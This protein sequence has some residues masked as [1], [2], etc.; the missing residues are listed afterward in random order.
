V[1]CASA[2]SFPSHTPSPFVNTATRHLHRLLSLVQPRPLLLNSK[3]PLRFCIDA[4]PAIREALGRFNYLNLHYT[5][6]KQHPNVLRFD[7]VVT[8]TTVGEEKKKSAMIVPLLFVFY[9]GRKYGLMLYLYLRGRVYFVFVL[10]ILL[11]FLQD[12]G[13]LRRGPLSPL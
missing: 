1:C 2:L 5:H 10:N 11:F 3:L 6:T 7:C 13:G 9:G 12:C 8:M 4:P